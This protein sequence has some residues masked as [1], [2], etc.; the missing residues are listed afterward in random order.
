MP[1]PPT[2]LLYYFIAVIYQREIFLR[3]GIFDRLIGILCQNDTVLLEGFVITE[4]FRL[5]AV[6][7]LRL[8]VLSKIGVDVLN[9]VNLPLYQGFQLPDIL[10]FLL[11]PKYFRKDVVKLVREVQ[12]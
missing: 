8:D 11:L 2:L 6:K 10:L 7:V 9:C 5:P 12:L 1:F 4:F 3:S